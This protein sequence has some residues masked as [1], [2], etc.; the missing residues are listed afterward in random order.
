MDTSYFSPTAKQALAAFNQ[1]KFTQAAFLFSD[2]AVEYENENQPLL[3]AEM[4]NN[5]SVSLLQ[6]NQAQSALECLIGVVE[7][8]E[9]SGD[10]HKAGLTHGNLAA[11]FEALNKYDLAADH[12]YKAADYLRDSNHREEYTMIMNM[13]V[14]IQMKQ[15]RIF[16]AAG[17]AHLFVDQIPN[18][19]FRQ[20]VLKIVYTI[21]KFFTKL[22]TR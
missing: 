17:S 6:A 8:F 3:A 1:Q 16:E 19:T 15:G 20:R 2:A 5:Q 21:Y 7:L 9:N 18:P 10:L 4:K 22:F 12:C 11:A 14:S 13:L